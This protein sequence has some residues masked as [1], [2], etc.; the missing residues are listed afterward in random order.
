ME[1]A[2]RVFTDRLVHEAQRELPRLER[3]RIVGLGRAAGADVAHLSPV[4]FGETAAPRESVPVE[5]LVGMAAD[6]GAHLMGQVER[7]GFGRKGHDK[8]LKPKYFAI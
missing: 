1:M 3:A 4:Q 5:A 6:K 7:L 2:G 8:L